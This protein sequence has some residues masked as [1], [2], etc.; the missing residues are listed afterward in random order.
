M[1]IT[2][3][4]K[5]GKHGQSQLVKKKCNLRWEYEAFPI[6]NAVEQYHS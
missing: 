5:K 6:F 3:T 1:F 4:K 2:Q